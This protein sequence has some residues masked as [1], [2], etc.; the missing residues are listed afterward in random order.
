M[1]PYLEK[2]LGQFDNVTPM[3]WHDSPYPHVEPKY[4]AKEQFAKYDESPAARKKKN[5]YMSKR[6]MASSYG[7][8]E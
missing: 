6:S 7:M 3:T 4:D 8:G 1:K 2:A 5:K